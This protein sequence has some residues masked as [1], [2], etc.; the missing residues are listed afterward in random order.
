[1]QLLLDIEE[2]EIDIEAQNIARFGTD[3]SKLD[4]LG[5][6]TTHNQAVKSFNSQLHGLCQNRTRQYADLYITY[7]NMYNIK[8]DFIAVLGAD[9]ESREQ[10]LVI[11]MTA[12]DI[13]VSNRRFLQR[14]FVISNSCNILYQDLKSLSTSVAYSQSL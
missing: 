5:C 6:L 7:V 2:S 11:N 12:C 13:K 9:L 10:P 8:L 14:N 3:P 4:E 1:M